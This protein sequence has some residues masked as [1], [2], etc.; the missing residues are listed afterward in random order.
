MREHIAAQDLANEIRML[1]TTFVG[2]FVIVEGRYDKLVYKRFFDSESCTIEIADGRNNVLGVIRILNADGAFSGVLGIVDADFANITGESI[3][4]NNIVQTDLHDLECMM[5]NS[6]AL[7]RVLDEHGADDRVAE[8]AKSNPQIARQLAT[9][10][11][12]LGC[13]RLISIQQTLELKFEGL[14]F[15]K[16]VDLDALQIDT[17][18]M[19]QAVVNN[20]QQHQL[21]QKQLAEQVENELQKKHDC[22][23]ISCGH[24]I[25]ELLSLG[26]RKIFSSKSGGAVTVGRLEQ[27]LRLAYDAS[28]FQETSLYQTMLDWEQRHPSFPILIGQSGNAPPQ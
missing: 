10:T 16:F 8:F 23:Q 7:D 15:S 20:S 24:D 26:F 19:V 11:V 25:V 2:A 5:L 1:R 27:S 3:Q 17:S 9:N 6:P 18:K 4:E 13:L 14:T 12:P 22:W 28:C 21:D